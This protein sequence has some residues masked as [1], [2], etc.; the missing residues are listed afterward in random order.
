MLY[1]RMLKKK[2][3]NIII[4]YLDMFFRF[5]WTQIWF[6]LKVGSLELKLSVVDS[7]LFWRESDGATEQIY[8][9]SQ[10]G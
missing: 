2:D 5:D 7:S 6:F 4:L 10:G 9:P 3:C 1:H 8:K